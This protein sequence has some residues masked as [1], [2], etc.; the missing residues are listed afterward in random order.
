MRE[1][2]GER[3]AAS[4]ADL[5]AGARPRTGDTPMTPRTMR[6]TKIAL[7]SLSMIAL[8]SLAPAAAADGI[9]VNPITVPGNCAFNDREY[10]V[11]WLIETASGGAINFVGCS[12]WIDHD[13]LLP[14]GGPG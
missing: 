1:D 6:T 3:A 14:E 2:N 8:A 4:F 11:Y 13:E 9:V 10:S 7:L 5:L 12:I